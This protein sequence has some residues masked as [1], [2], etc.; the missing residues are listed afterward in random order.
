MRY[1]YSITCKFF[2]PLVTGSFHRISTG[3]NC[4][5]IHWI[6]YITQ[7]DVNCSGICE[8]SRLY[9][10]SVTFLVSARLFQRFCLRLVPSLPSDSW[11]FSALL[12]I[13]VIWPVF[14]FF[15]TH[16]MFWLRSTILKFSSW[17]L[18]LAIV[19]SS[20]YEDLLESRNPTELFSFH[21]IGQ[22][23]IKSFHNFHLIT[24][25]T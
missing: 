16:S 24:F 20:E 9:R 7:A 2:T 1:F 14:A 3:S 6:L 19:F 15:Y 11:T 23:M 13:S 17:W 25:P 22:I 21:F 12:Q 4:L 5:Q 10:F 8:W 18:I